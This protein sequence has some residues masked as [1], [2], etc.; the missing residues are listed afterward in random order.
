MNQGSDPEMSI[1]PDSIEAEHKAAINSLTSDQQRA[2][3]RVRRASQ[4]SHFNHRRVVE[5]L[6]QIFAEEAKRRSEG[7]MTAS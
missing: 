7:L 3:A 2:L 1:T 5:N 6:A 4:M